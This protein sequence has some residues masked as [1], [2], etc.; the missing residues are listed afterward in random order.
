MP[1]DVHEKSHQWEDNKGTATPDP[2]DPA[3]C[4][5]DGLW[6]ELRH[7]FELTSPRTGVVLVGWFESL[8]EDGD[9]MQ[10]DLSGKPLLAHAIEGITPAVD[11]VVNCHKV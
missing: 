1:V 6:D 3:G 11:A 9:K 5:T 7:Q 2:T 4:P 8:L 10:A